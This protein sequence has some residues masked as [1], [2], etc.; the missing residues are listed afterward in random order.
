MNNGRSALRY[1]LPA[2]EKTSPKRFLTHKKHSRPPYRVC[3]DSIRAISPLNDIPLYCYT[4]NRVCVCV[5]GLSEDLRRRRGVYAQAP[6]EISRKRRVYREKERGQVRANTRAREMCVFPYWCVHILLPELIGTF[7][8]ALYYISHRTSLPHLVLS[9]YL[10]HCCSRALHFSS[11]FVCVT[12]IREK[13]Y[14]PLSLAVYIYSCA[15]FFFS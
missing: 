7:F 8:L 3:F 11:L 9:I 6:I 5:L 10:E 13:Y 14:N 15:F 12:H 4:H 1:I 2:R